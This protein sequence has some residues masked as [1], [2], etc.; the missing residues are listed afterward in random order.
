MKKKI[1]WEHMTV[2]RTNPLTSSDLD[3][4]CNGDDDTDTGG[5]EFVTSMHFYSHPADNFVFLYYFKRVKP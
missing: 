4:Y 2:T 5:W 1:I 3:F